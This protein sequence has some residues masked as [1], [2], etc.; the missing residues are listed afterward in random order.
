MAHLK[1]E[2]RA[3]Y[4]RRM[5]AGIAGRYDLMNRVMTAGQDVRWRRYVVAQ[6]ALPANGRLLDIAT[7]T[8]DIALEAVR[9][10]PSVQ[11]VGGD[12]TLEMMQ[13]GKLYPERQMIQWVGADTLALPFPT[14]YFDAVTSGFLMRNVI[15]VEQALREQMRVL[16]PG[17]R[18]VILESS[19]PKKNL[20]RPFILIHLNYV[21]PLLGRLIAGSSE[22]YS[23]LPNSTKQFRSPEA[24][25]EA[26]GEA[27]LT[28]V[29]FKLFM[30]GTIAIH[31][32]TKP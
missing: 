11:P 26:M 27:G 22:A 4:V 2:E 12:F 21:I 9:Q 8:G 31:V 14:G 5:F 28:Q 16:K 15:D 19:P 17:G 20:L 30:F 13:A 29:G 32:G 10:V 24:L 3:R 7:G 18:L 1:G 25:A 23:Y 6:A